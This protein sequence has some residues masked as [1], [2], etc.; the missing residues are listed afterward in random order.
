LIFLAFATLLQTTPC[1]PL[2]AFIPPE[3]GDGFVY[4]TSVNGQALDILMRI[5][6][7]SA[8]GLSTAFR[9]GGGPTLN[10]IEMSPGS[11][12]RGYAGPAFPRSAGSG[13]RRREWSYSPSPDSVLETLDVGETVQIHAQRRNGGAGERYILA[14]TFDACE[15]LVIDG[16]A[17]ATNIY[18]IERVDEAGETTPE[19][20]VWLS[21][22]S[23]WWLREDDM[24]ASTSTRM[25]LIED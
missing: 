2:D 11:P 13:P 18:A 8:S 4:E 6:V 7:V 10:M 5:E 16:Q 20:R 19:R 15:A 23:G 9:Q 22:A 25:T 17:I 3:P 1:A 12:T 14:V 24:T 21:S